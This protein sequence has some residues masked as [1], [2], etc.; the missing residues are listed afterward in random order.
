MI[1][2]FRVYCFNLFVG[3]FKHI[4]QL[5]FHQNND[6]VGTINYSNFTDLIVKII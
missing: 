6:I 1:L 4:Y 5:D 2:S 3:V